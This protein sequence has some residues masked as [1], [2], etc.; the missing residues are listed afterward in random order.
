MSFLHV[1]GG[2][3]I[4]GGQ[5]DAEGFS[6]SFEGQGEGSVPEAAWPGPWQLGDSDVVEKMVGPTL[7]PTVVWPRPKTTIHPSPW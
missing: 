4:S 2:M 6:Q 7:C 3:W 5:E 1:V